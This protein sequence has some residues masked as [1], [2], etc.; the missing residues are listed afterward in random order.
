[1]CECYF[2]FNSLTGAQNASFMLKKNAIAAAV[3]SSHSEFA[4]KGCGYAVRIDADYVHSAASL[5]RREN[6]VFTNAYRLCIGNTPEE[7]VV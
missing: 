3:V 1:M 4:S 6:I 5:L 2:V 7:V